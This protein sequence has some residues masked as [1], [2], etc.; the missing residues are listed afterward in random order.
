MKTTPPIKGLDFILPVVAIRLAA[1]TLAGWV[2]VAIHMERDHGAGLHPPPPAVD[3]QSQA[4]G[5]PRLTEERLRDML[6]HD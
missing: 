2:I 3:V 6:L 1:I 5:A 4:K